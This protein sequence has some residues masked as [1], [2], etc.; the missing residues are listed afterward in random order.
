MGVTTV[1]DQPFKIL[2]IAGSLAR[3]ASWNWGLIRA[4]IEGAPDGIEIVTL[5]LDLVPLYNQDVMDAGGVSTT[6]PT[7]DPRQPAR[8]SSAAERGRRRRG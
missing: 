2:A 5:D 3:R 7:V 6:R 8:R 1:S 4:A